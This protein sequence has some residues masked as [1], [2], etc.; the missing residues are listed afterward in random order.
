VNK[1][2]PNTKIKDILSTIT[3]FGSVSIET[4]PPSVVIKITKAK[5]AQIVSVTQHP[6]VKSLSDIKLTLPTTFN[7][8]KRKGNIYML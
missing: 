1:V 5:Q 7:I 4:S 2:L 6:P 3:T 8:Q